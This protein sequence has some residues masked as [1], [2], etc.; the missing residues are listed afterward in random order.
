M[1]SIDLIETCGYKANKNRLN[2]KEGTKYD[3]KIKQKKMITFDEV[4]KENLKKNII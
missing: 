1:Q 3:N 4:T 2:E